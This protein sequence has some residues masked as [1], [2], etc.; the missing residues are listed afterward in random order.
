MIVVQNLSKILK[1][2]NIKLNNCINNKINNQTSHMK[3]EE[4]QIKNL[5]LVI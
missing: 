2:K 3:V 4:N 1:N 5:H